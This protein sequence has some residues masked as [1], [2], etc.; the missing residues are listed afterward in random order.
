MCRSRREFSNAYLV[1]KF[2]FDADENEPCEVCYADEPSCEAD[3]LRA[4]AAAP[5]RELT[6]DAVL[7]RLAAACE[8]LQASFAGFWPASWKRRGGHV[9]KE[10]KVTHR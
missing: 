6:A 8:Q 7:S 1:A 2:H 5:A 3:T 4:V 10:I 9:F